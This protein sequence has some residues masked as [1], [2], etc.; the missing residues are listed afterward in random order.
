MFGSHFAPFHVLE[1]LTDKVFKGQRRYYYDCIMSPFASNVKKALE[2]LKA[3]NLRINAI[4]PSHGPVLDKDPQEAISHYDR[5]S[6]AYDSPGGQKRVFIPYVSS[7]GYTAQLANI[8]SDELTAQGCETDVVDI[9]ELPSEEVTHRI[10]AADALALGSP[11]INQDAL[12]PVWLALSHVSVPLVRGRKAIVFGSYG[13]SGEG[14]PFRTA[15][16]NLGFKV[17]GMLRVRFRPDEKSPDA[18]PWRNPRRSAEIS[19]IKP[20]T[21]RVFAVCKT[22]IPFKAMYFVLSGE[23]VVHMTS[24]SSSFAML[25]RG[26]CRTW[27][28]PPPRTLLVRM[29]RSTCCSVLPPSPDV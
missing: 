5:W 17:V 27:R 22:S 29:Q 14:V 28:S 12:P 13:W 26:A 11:T 19:N 1:S 6:R 4:L 8:I 23:M 25:N 16:T 7:Y 3:L 2:T 15:V 24:T 20:G 18:A 21:L 10:H 9:A